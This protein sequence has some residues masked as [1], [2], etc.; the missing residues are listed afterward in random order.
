MKETL[1]GWITASE[2]A[3]RLGVST[4][5]IQWLANH[6][7]L[8]DYVM[9]GTA[10]VVREEEVTRLVQARDEER[11]SSDWLTITEAATQLG[12]SRYSVYR[13]ATYIDRQAT[14]PAV[15]SKRSVLHDA[16]LVFRPDI[17]R[18]LEAQDDHHGNNG[19]GGAAA[20]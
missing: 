7:K 12:V 4:Q 10:R 6:G 2:A 3:R 15:A 16:L 19:A 5:G 14:V 9:F 1:E 11:R 17:V 8:S 13:K 20:E 18:I